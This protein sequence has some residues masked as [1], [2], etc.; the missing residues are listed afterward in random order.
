MNWIELANPACRLGEGVCWSHARQALMFVDIHGKRILQYDV[1]TGQL[2]EWASPQ[3][4]GWLIPRLE[5]DGFLAGFQEGFAFIELNNNGGKVTPHWLVKPFGQQNH[6]RLNDA[7][8]DTRGRVWAGSLNNEDES[9]PQGVLFRLLPDGH[10]DTMDTGYGV[11]NGPAISVDGK[12]LLHT[13]SAQR[14]IYA[15]D[16]DP[17]TGRLGNKR[18]WR[19]FAV[20]EGYPDGMN[21]DAQ[22]RIWVAHW[23]AG[24]ISQFGLDGA[25][26]QRLKLPV[27]NVT[28]IA[29]GGPK[30]ERMFVTTA[31]QGLSD[32]QRQLEPLAGALFEI[33][34]HGATGMAPLP[35]WG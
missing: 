16:L 13:D 12:V 15:F 29:F 1:Q 8:A 14:T 21:F 11:A 3:R 2:K 25:L 22:G 26:L 28:N 18:V 33:T 35:Y 10:L 32:M 23:R 6:L 7:K 9:Q 4:I 5:R 24:C 31:Y 27:S 20:D 34:G 19:V 30:L 17:A